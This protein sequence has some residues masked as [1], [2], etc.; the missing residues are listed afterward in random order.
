MQSNHSCKLLLFDFGAVIVNLDKQRC[1]KALRQIGCGQIANYVDEHRSEDLFH[2]LELGGSN[3]NFCQEAREKSNC[4]ATD[5]EICWAW[6]EL[7]TDIPLEKLR[8][9]QHYH[10]TLGYKTALLSNTNWIHW[11]HSKKFFRADGRKVEDYFDNLFLSC[12]LGIIKPDRKIYEEVIEKT[13]VSADNILFIDDSLTNSI[14]A[15]SMGIKTIH[16]PSGNA[17][18]QPKAAIIGNFDGIHLGHQHIINQLKEVASGSPTPLST[19][20]ITFDRHPKA[21]FNS[22]FIPKYITTLKEKERQLLKTG[23]DCVAIMPFN[24]NFSKITAYDFMKMLHDEMAVKVLVVGYDNRFGAKIEG[25]EETFEDYQRYG[26][27]IGIEVIQAS[28]REDSDNHVS[29]SVVRKLIISGDMDAA[30]KGLGRRFSITGKVVKGHQNGRKIGFPTA[31]MIP[32]EDQLLPPNG[33]YATSVGN[34]K[35]MTNIGTRPTFDGHQLTIETYILDFNEDLY[36]KEITV[37]FERYIR[38]ERTF[39][40]PKELMEQIKKDIEKVAS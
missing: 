6:N 35:A 19:M 30:N 23:L 15:I 8:I 13:G 14:G 40:S 29:S 2:E 17:W 11:E 3:E 34:H 32:Q 12:D 31:N 5:E 21:L 1:I 9:I 28:P 38:E 7:L 33:V 26:K 20:A 18:K 10:D 36:D 39:S 22:S 25:K 24:E 4:N 37:E 16:D 27:E